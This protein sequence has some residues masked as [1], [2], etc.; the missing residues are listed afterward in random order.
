MNSKT[1]F[2][3]GLMV[4][5]LILSV[6][7]VSA[8]TWT[9]S[10]DYSKE[11]IREISFS[12]W[13]G[14]GEEQGSLTLKSHELDSEGGIKTLKT[15]LGWQVTMYYDF[16]FKE[17]ITDSLG[18]VEFID[19]KSGESV[20]KEYKF[21]YWFE[22]ERVRDVCLEY[23]VVSNS[24]K[25]FKTEPKCLK[26]G[27]ETYNFSEWRDY[28]SRDIP[29]SGRIGVMVNNKQGDYIDGI[30]NLGSKKLD[31][32]AEWTA[33]LENDLISW[34][35]LDETSGDV[36]DGFG[37]NNGTNYGATRGVE[38]KIGNAFDFDGTNDYVSFE[39]LTDNLQSFTTSQ[40]IYV[41]GSNGGRL[42]E[43]SGNI[44]TSFIDEDMRI[45]VYI[46]GVTSDW[47]RTP[48]NS[49]TD[50]TWHHIVFEYDKDN[51]K[52]RVY[53][54]GNL[55]VEST[56]SGDVIDPDGKYFTAGR[57]NDVGDGYF[58]GKIDEVGI[59]SR[60]LTSDEVEALYNNG[61]GLNYEDKINIEL[62]NPEDN[63]IT[64]Q[65][66]INFSANVILYRG[67]IE[68]ENVS[69]LINGVINETNS[70]GDEGIYNF[71]KTL[72]EGDYNWSIMAYDNESVQYNSS[73]YDL[74]IE[75]QPPQIEINSGNGTFDY[76]VLTQNHTINFTI[77]SDLLDQCWY[78]YNGT[79]SSD[80]GCSSEVLESINF[81]L[82]KDVYNA[83]IYANDTAGNIESE[84]V[85]WDY[86]VFENAF[87]YNNEIISGNQESYS[88]QITLGEDYDLT[89]AIFHYGDLTS[90]PA[91]YS[92]G[93]NRILNI[94]NYFIPIY[95]TNT[96]VSIW[97][98][99]FLDD[100]TT[101]NT[102]NHT[103]LVQAIF[104]DTCSSYTNTLFNISLFDEVTQDPLNGDI[105]FYYSLLNMPSH[106]RVASSNLSLS[107]E[108]NFAI[109]SAI[110]L[111]NQNYVQ[112]IEIRYVADGHVPELYHIQKAEISP[113][114]TNI[115]LYS[116]NQNDSTEFKI[117]YQDDSFNFVE[118]AIV[119]LLRR[120]ISEDSY[121]VVEAP[122]TSNEGVAVLHIDLNSIKY[123]AI[124][125]KDGV[126]LD[127]FE[128]LVFKCQSE[129]T[130][131]CEQ[132]LLGEINPQ[133]SLDYDTQR[134][135]SY[136]VTAGDDKIK[137]TFSIPSGSQS[138]INVEAI[139]KDTFGNK[140][141]CNKTITSSGGSLEC[142]YD[143]SLGISYLELNIKKDGE[144]I[145]YN[146]YVIDEQVG[147]DFLGDNYIIVIVLMLSLVGMA[148]SSPEWI[149]INGILSL[150][151]SGMLWLVNG[152]GFVAGLGIL[153][154]LVIGAGILILKLAKQEDK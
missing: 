125:V 19:M 16:D 24:T 15:G 4:L 153:M 13:W 84:V 14:L 117:I 83:T 46:S 18:D 55:E 79:N 100:S 110:N 116:L 144:L 109:C 105:E 44:Q 89:S 28:N 3:V 60:A 45:I 152:I 93:N 113:E 39:G 71:S 35:K 128:N 51:S 42:F 22:E 5:T 114:V 134:D 49:I 99:L 80:L 154:W 66:T 143:D 118:G 145:S 141:V 9:K 47:V 88:Y 62:L 146:T 133:N 41:D 56:Q 86:R 29:T 34:Y 131:E 23:E 72:T 101:I 30:W 82:E 58:K 69:L 137:V 150:L 120:Y 87:I 17:L 31:R 32:H 78:E 107:E 132:K 40:W 135:F 104:L 95:T 139:Q 140:T 148:L 38:G 1:L 2:L 53:I 81:T 77:T 124:V 68:I 6:N 61:N 103:Q 57:R 75:T 151:L 147:I 129:L 33:N 115:S 97:F 10:L 26:E 122:I 67:D 48:I 64:N 92:E 52:V 91:I 85:E 96:N 59:W 76:G 126:I 74:T 121:K 102:L 27:T 98:E 54:D 36:V 12:N 37:S 142:S 136:S 90:S 25:T 108:S 127:T 7:F 111:S 8:T 21:V 119:Q 65:E 138:I 123:K 11:D 149:I 70:S 63:T 106:Q 20:D 112:S 73:V 50:S 43:R 130:G 94:S